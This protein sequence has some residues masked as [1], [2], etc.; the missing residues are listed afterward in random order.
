MQV[1]LSNTQRWTE[2]TKR[3]KQVGQDKQDQAT[4]LVIWKWDTGSANTKDENR[5]KRTYRSRNSLWDGGEG[6]H[7]GE[8]PLSTGASRHPTWP[9]IFAVELN[10]IKSGSRIKEWGIQE[11]SSG[12]YPPN[13]P[14]IG[15]LGPGVRHPPNA[16]PY[17]QAGAMKNSTFSISEALSASGDQLKPVDIQKWVSWEVR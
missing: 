13:R 9:I 7:S 5:N 14:G 3:T 8:L 15:D 2:S 16:A 1:K 10:V 11:H 4:E 12:P 6:K 17:R